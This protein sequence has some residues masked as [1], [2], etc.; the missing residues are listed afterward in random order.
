M[1]CGSKRLK[2]VL[3]FAIDCSG[4][5]LFLALMIDRI[6]YYIKEVRMLRKHMEAIK[7]SE[8]KSEEAKKGKGKAE[9]D[10]SS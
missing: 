3:N 6:H 4:F 10:D 8:H 5:A 1:I 2:L 7:R 9:D